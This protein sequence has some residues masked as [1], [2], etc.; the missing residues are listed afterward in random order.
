MCGIAFLV[1]WLMPGTL[2]ISLNE[3]TRAWPARTEKV[4]WGGR[5]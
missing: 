1:F 3:C 4:R 2:K 5:P